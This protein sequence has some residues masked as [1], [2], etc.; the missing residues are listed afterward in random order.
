MTDANTMVL[1]N[2]SI[3]TLFLSSC[4]LSWQGQVTQ[5]IGEMLMTADLF[6]KKQRTMCKS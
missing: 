5:Q 4:L 3:L 2:I 1:L 6:K